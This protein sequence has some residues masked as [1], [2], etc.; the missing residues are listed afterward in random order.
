MAFINSFEEDDFEEDIPDV[1]I[2]RSSTRDILKVCPVCFS[3][4]KIE[5]ATIFMVIFACTKEDC[6]WSGPIAIEVFQDDYNDFFEKQKESE[7]N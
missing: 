5:N 2:K 7:Q 1:K 6:G 3:P 4:A